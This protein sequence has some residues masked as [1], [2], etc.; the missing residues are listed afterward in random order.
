VI[1]IGDALK[2]QLVEKEQEAAILRGI[3]R[4]SIAASG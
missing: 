4:V 2:S 1:S 3:A